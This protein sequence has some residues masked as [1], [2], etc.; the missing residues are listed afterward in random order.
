MDSANVSSSDV[1]E[2]KPYFN[3]LYSSFI[4]FICSI[5]NTEDLNQS[6]EH[7]QDRL[8]NENL[9]P[10]LLSEFKKHIKNILSS[11]DGF[12]LL[13]HELLELG[14]SYH[15]LPE[16]LKDVIFNLGSVRNDII[17]FMPSYI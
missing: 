17:T 6:F 16:D 12:P 7:P 4:D 3:A 1:K 15:D 14:G 5:R 11:K 8:L 10:G 9:H 13:N 2:S